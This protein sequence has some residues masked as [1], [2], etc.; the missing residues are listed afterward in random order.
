MFLD[1][2]VEDIRRVIDLFRMYRFLSG[3]GLG[4]GLKGSIIWVVMVFLYVFYF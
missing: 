1:G 2:L 3:F 4:R